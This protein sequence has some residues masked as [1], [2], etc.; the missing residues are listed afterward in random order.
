M[1]TTAWIGYTTLSIKATDQSAT[2]IHAIRAAAMT[3]GF[4][5]LP[6]TATC[7]VITHPRGA[8]ENEAER[9]NIRTRE[10]IRIPG[11]VRAA[12]AGFLKPHIRWRARRRGS[13][14]VGWCNAWGD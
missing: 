1:I 3:A 11:F 6:A 9:T 14:R 8:H 2:D 12:L 13:G 7:W 10:I 4:V 5:A